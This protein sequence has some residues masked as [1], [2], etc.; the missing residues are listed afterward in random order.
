MISAVPE[1]GQGL[2][3]TLVV[4]MVLGIGAAGVLI[5]LSGGG[6]GPGSLPTDVTVSRVSGSA[7]G[8]AISAAAIAACRTNYAVASQAVDEYEAQHG[9]LPKR[10]A[11]VQA[12]LKDPLST[13]QFTITIDS[14]NPGQLEVATRGHLA[15]DGP[16]NCAFAGS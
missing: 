15:S 9:K 2:I 13:R 16:S 3:G 11:D 6:S 4:L 1:R 14:A 5:S 12:Y 7:G 8:G 10:T